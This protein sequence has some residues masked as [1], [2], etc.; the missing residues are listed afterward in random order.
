MFY[1]YLS[2]VC[3]ILLACLSARDAIANEPSIERWDRAICLIQ[4]EVDQET[5]KQ[6]H[7]W[8]TAFL[9]TDGEHVTM[10]ATAH[11]ARA[12]SRETIVLF[13]TAE[14]DSAAVGLA[15]LY[16]GEG[17]PWRQQA[18]ADVAV[19]RIVPAEKEKENETIQA[20]LKL[21]IP[22]E[23]V[24]TTLPTRTTPVELTGFPLGLGIKGVGVQSEVSSIVV[25]GQ[26][27]SREM[28]VPAKWG[29]ETV[30][31]IQLA[32]AGGISGSP[33]FL[34]EESPQSVQLVG[35][36]MGYVRE[37]KSGLMM[38]R[39]IPGRILADAVNNS[40]SRFTQ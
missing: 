33:V 19:M 25:C 12:T 17:N 27:A 23:S 30:F 28:P 24:Q 9:V 1:G 15:E 37:D 29:S 31:L 16:Q 20:L 32:G 3:G 5:K 13:R 14:G 21:A 11:G 7:E 8:S 38:S 36:V 10:V 35:M 26:I 18:N 22:L 40:Y 6:K 34:Q 4:R 39:I 2:A